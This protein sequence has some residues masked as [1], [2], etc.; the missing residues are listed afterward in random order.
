MAYEQIYA[1]VNSAV[2]QALGANAVTVTDTSGLVEVG[3]Q[4]LSDESGL[5]LQ[6]FM[7]GLV[8]AIT[9]TRIKAK[10]Y[11]GGETVRAYRS[12]EDFGLYRRKIQVDNIRDSAENSSYKA[13]NWAYYNGSPTKN[14]TD[15]LFGNIAGLETAPDIVPRKQY[16]RCFANAGEMAQFIS[17][18]DTSRLNSIRC[19]M[20]S[21]G[22]LAR[23]TAMIDCA[24]SVNTCVD[25]GAI[26]NAVTGKATTPKSWLYD[27]DLARFMLVEMKRIIERLKPMNRI[28][29][30]AGCD[31]FTDESDL[32][33]DMHADFVA[34]LEGYALNT[35]ISPFLTLPNFNKV[36]RWQGRGVS[37]AVDN[38]DPYKLYLKNTDI[39]F[40]TEEE[41]VNQIEL[42]G[43]ICFA[44]DVDKYALTIDDMRTV[45]AVN[46]LQEMTTTVTKYD[47][48]YAV[49]PSEQGIIFFVGYHAAT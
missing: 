38:F 19:D 24:R 46:Q 3:G 34:T 21:C 13:Q 30:N 48:S 27:A 39:N 16:A 29:N 33:I 41:P 7:N 14:W 36:T 12:A 47:V 22:I 40:G 15:R 43:I 6:T 2:K 44:H 8:G 42:D 26:Y 10:S 28:Y 31:R 4:I 49:D 25:L 35:L 1:M 17:M 11:T 18:L 37:D 5:T 23:G 9:K 20:E 32:I 45:T